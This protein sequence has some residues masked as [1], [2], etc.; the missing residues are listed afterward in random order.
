MPIIES[1]IE[2]LDSKLT[3]NELRPYVSKYSDALDDIID[4]YNIFFDFNKLVPKPNRIVAND[5]LWDNWGTN[6]NSLYTR[7]DIDDGLLYL[8]TQDSP[9]VPVIQELSKQLKCRFKITYS[10][11]DIGR[12]NGYVI[13]DNGDITDDTLYEDM[14]QDALG[15]YCDIWADEL[16]EKDENGRFVIV[17]D[18]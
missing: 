18:G 6:C 4:G 14:S 9:P 16:V 7:I 10:S 1:K 3:E 5:W 12:I 13:C 8:Q 2:K 15:I 17:S 11:D